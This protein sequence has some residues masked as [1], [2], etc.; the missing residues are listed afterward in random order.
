ML[1]AQVSR[2]ERPADLH[3]VA[4]LEVVRDVAGHAPVRHQTN[5]ELEQAV[6]GQSGH[7]VRPGMFRCELQ[8]HVLAR[9]KRHRLGRAQ[10]QPLD[11]VGQVLK[12]DDRRL[13]DA[14]RVHHH[15]VGLRYLDRAGLGEVGLAGQHVA[16]FA[17][18]RPL[19]FARPF[20][21]LAIEHPATAG[22]AA[23]GHAR[24][25][26]RHLGVLQRLQQVGAGLDPDDT[27]EGLN[28]DVHGEFDEVPGSFLVRAIRQIE[29]LECDVS[30]A[31]M[32][33]PWSC[34]TSISTSWC[35]SSS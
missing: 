34:R 29:W 35:F 6:A 26:H 31:V 30:L 4:D 18:Q 14:R 2:P 9:R 22:A 12:G 19:L 11:V 7:G 28:E 25:R 1:A 21:H 13:D 3:G 8:L 15:L 10:H 23:P 17:G 24:V 33:R 5:V 32:E 16:L 27:V 20:H